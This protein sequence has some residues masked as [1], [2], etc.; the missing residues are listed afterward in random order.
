M[1]KTI[2]ETAGPLTAGIGMGLAMSAAMIERLDGKMS[3]VEIATV[4]DTVPLQ[5]Q[6]AT[7]ISNGILRDVQDGQDEPRFFHVVA[8]S[9]CDI[10]LDAHRE[11]LARRAAAGEAG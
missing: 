5:I 3:P 11:A 6:I 9:I 8:D 10:V 7:I 4:L 1:M 2:E